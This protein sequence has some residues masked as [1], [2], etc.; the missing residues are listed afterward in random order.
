M[1]LKKKYLRLRLEIDAL[2]LELLQQELVQSLLVL[3]QLDLPSQRR[4]PIEI[5]QM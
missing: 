2:L 4:V 1:L 3:V 5:I